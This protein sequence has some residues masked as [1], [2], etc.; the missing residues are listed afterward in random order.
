[1]FENKK[2]VINKNTYNSSIFKFIDPNNNDKLSHISGIDLQNL[3]VLI[4]DYYI[5]L[6][7]QLYF[8]QNVTFGL[9]LEFENAKREKIQDELNKL[10]PE[11][12]WL[13]KNDSSLNNGAEINSP[14]LKDNKKSWE[15]LNK[16][17]SILKKYAS[18]DVNS[19]GHIHVG[20]QALGKDVNSWL[21]FIQ[22]WSVYENIIYRFSCGEFL[23]TR[24]RILNYAKPLSKEFMHIYKELSDG[25]LSLGKIIDQISTQKYQAVNFD[26]VLVNC[27]D[28]FAEFNTI[29]FRCPNGSLNPV[30]WQNNVN[31]FVHILSYCRSSIFDKDIIKK[32]YKI[33]KDK[34]SELKW[35]DEIYL[36]QAL[37]LCDMIFTNNFDKVYFLKQYLKSFQVCKNHSNYIKARRLTKC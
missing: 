8:E 2:K 9:E 26:N 6:R 18:I 25:S 13:L 5:S 19:G 36:D 15:D 33:N 4:N 16:V 11:K 12:Y 29:E 34:F 1:M 30:I 3:I 27:C 22:F 10:F 14:I 21:N 24:P 23:T 7:D 35:Y 20:T 32:R 31:F 17:C 37:E 28:R